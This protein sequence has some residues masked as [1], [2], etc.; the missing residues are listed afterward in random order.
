MCSRIAAEALAQQ[1]S[2]SSSADLPDL[3][4]LLKAASR[5]R[6]KNVAKSANCIEITIFNPLFG[7]GQCHEHGLGHGQVVIVKFMIMTKG[8]PYRYRAASVDKNVEKDLRD[9]LKATT[10]K[11][12]S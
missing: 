11:L 10:H 9:L 8:L 4:D 5:K 1:N 12:Q 6:H 7:H 2:S 3:P